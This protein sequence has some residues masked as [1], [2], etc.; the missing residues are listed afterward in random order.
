MTVKSW[1]PDDHLRHFLY[2]SVHSTLKEMTWEDRIY[3]VLDFGSMWFGD[4]DGG[5]QTFMRTLLKDVLGTKNVNHILGT[6]PEYDAETLTSV[7][8]NS[9]DI[10][11]A[12]QVLE[13]VQ[14]PWV[15][16]QTFYQKLKI[17]GVAIIA[18]PGL[19]PIHPSPF[20]CWRIMPDGYRVLFPEGPWKTMVFDTWGS[21][22]RVGYEFTNNKELIKGGRTYTVE[23][24]AE[25]PF[26]S[27][28]DKLCPIQLWWV[29][30]KVR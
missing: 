27:D 28:N 23:E 20:D 29:G 22:Q 3:D 13:H 14:R 16:A 4:P 12:D 9:L 2:E 30:V 7:M 21:A 18:T 6:Y 19:Y 10:I 1:S 26:Y 17:G 11:V 8:N 25:Q 24:A 5:W 15:A